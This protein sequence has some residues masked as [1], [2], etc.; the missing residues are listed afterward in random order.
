VTISEFR[1]WLEG[2][3]ASFTEAPSAEQWQTIQAKLATVRTYDDHQAAPLYPTTQQ[4]QRYWWQTPVIGSAQTAVPN[5]NS[6]SGV[7]WVQL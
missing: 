2:Y 6:A 4:Y 1:A 5:E 7:R 3:Q